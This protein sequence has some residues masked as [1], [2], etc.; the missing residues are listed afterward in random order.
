MKQ[1]KVIDMDGSG[2]EKNVTNLVRRSHASGLDLRKAEELGLFTRISNLVCAI[3]ALNITACR[4]KGEVDNLFDM[5]GARRHEIKRELEAIDKA[6]DRFVS[7]FRGYQTLDGVRDMNEESEVLY[8]Q[9]MRWC[10]IP[11]HWSLGDKQYTGAETEPLVTVECGNMDVNFYVSEIDHEDLSEPEES[12]CVTKY[13]RKT[14]QQETTEDD[15]DKA[16][17]QMVAKRMSVNDPE[18]MYTV[19]KL[20]TYTRRTTYATPMKVFANGE[21]VGSYRKVLKSNNK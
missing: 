2:Y 12:F 15:V 8:H 14:R 5:A 16:S 1:E 17:A 3:H 10:Q 18:N 19:S 11:E 4:L 20:T 7:F 21:M 13:D 9:F 6:F